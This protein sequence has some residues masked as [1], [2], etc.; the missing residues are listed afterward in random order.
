VPVCSPTLIAEVLPKRVRAAV[1]RTVRDAKLDSRAAR[2]RLPARSEPYWRVIFEGAHLGYYRGARIGK[3]VARFREPGANRAGYLK[4]TIGEADDVTDAD[5]IRFLDFKQAQELARAWFDKV[6][7][8]QPSKTEFTVG[9]ALDEYMASFRGK[10]V[11]ATRSRIEA[12]IKPE[13][14]SI[15]VS[16]LTRKTVSDWHQ[17]RGHS[18]ARLRTSKRATT[19]NLR[20]ADDEEAI[21]KRRSTAN[22]DLTVLKAALN[23]AADY[24]EGL[25]VDSWR[26]VRPFQNVDRAKLRYLSEAEARRLVNGTAENFRPLVQAALLTGAR[27]GEIR[28]LRVKDF[29]NAAGVLC[30]SETKS[31]TPR[32]VYLEAEGKLLF[33]RATAGKAPSDLIFSRSDGN[34][35]SASQQAR[36][37][38][39]ASKRAKLEPTTFHDLRRT[40]G[41]R[42]A[43][44]GVPMAVIAEALG[45][46][47]ERITRK[48]YAHLSPSYVADT[49]R[50]TVAGLNIVSKDNV[51]SITSHKHHG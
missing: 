44:K 22:R 15:A 51:H 10:S 19:P 32:A 33:S 41:A 3:W 50:Q 31:G 42:L 6:R 35:W 9:D 17:R 45:H 38:L 26:L 14:G 16:D 30:L 1:A 20:P 25:P 48:H 28:G 8:G 4:S 21:R 37:L 47:D 2:S 43:V 18:P 24:H 7:R 13:L 49:I 36:P 46:A 29:D 23:R 39:E 40:Y 5:G 27:Y 12:I 34:R 11:A